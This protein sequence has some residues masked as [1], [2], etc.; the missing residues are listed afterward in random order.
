MLK[1]K[2]TFVV[3][4]GQ[5]LLIVGAAMA[6]VVAGTPNWGFGPGVSFDAQ[7]V[8]T[9]SILALPLGALAAALD[10]IENRF[11]ALK[12]VSTATQRSVLALLGG[13][14]KPRVALAIAM[15]LGMA[16]GLGEELLFRGV[17]QYELNARFGAALAVGVSSVIFGALHAVTPLYAALAAIASIYFGALYLVTGNLCVPIACHAVYDVGA[18]MY[19]HWVVSRLTDSEQHALATWEGPS[20]AVR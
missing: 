18:L 2:T 15:A 16:A 19:A 9:G 20:S 13:T 14:W 17:L 11:P 6:A 5:S 8:L 10:L 7:S 4:G 12:D 3:I 1:A